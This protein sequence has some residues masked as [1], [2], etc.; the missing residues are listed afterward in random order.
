MNISRQI[1]TS[2]GNVLDVARDSTINRMWPLTMHIYI[3]FIFFG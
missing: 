1:A 2:I 3:F